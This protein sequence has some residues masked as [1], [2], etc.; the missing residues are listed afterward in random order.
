MKWITEGK[1]QIAYGD[2]GRFE[3]EKHRGFYYGKYISDDKN[4]NF[5]RTTKI[6]EMK[7]RIQNNMYW[8]D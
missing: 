1:K 5:P 8:E 2:Y 7:N 6:K 3:I 4:F